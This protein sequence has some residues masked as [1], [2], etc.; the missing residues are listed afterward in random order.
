MAAEPVAAMSDAAADVA[1]LVAS[2]TSSQA[3]ATESPRADL[4]DGVRA[5]LATNLVG[6]RIARDSEESAG[7][8]VQGAAARLMAAVTQAQAVTSA[9]GTAGSGSRGRG[10]GESFAGNAERSPSSERTSSTAV[11][12]STAHGF[13]DAVIGSSASVMATPDTTASGAA[14]PSEGEPAPESRTMS[15]QVVK[16]ISMAWKDGTGEAKIT[17]SPDHLG[18]VTVSM[19]VAH[20]MVTADVQAS[21]QAARE[22]IQAHEQDLREKLAEQGLHLDQ[23]VVTADGQRQQQQQQDDARAQNR[24]VYQRNRSSLA[25]FE[26]NT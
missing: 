5:L 2:T 19:R 22:W 4:T 6:V 26:L 7:A 14:A 12:A 17:L 18:Q 20:G 1:R 25:R 8:D 23:L 15:G 21:T 9:L 3:A 10:T 24:R 13:L 11:I 16:A